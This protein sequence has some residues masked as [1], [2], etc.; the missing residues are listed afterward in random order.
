MVDVANKYYAGKGDMLLLQIDANLLS[1]ILKWEPPAHIDG[2]PALPNEPHYPHIYGPINIAAVTDVIKFPCL[3]DG[4]FATPP[5]LHTFTICNIADV[6]QHWLQAAQW[7]VTTWAYEFPNDTVQTYLDL[8]AHSSGTTT[9][10]AETFAAIN[11]RGELLGVVTLIDDDGLPDATEPGPWV[12]ALFVNPTLR[13]H[14]VGNALLQLATNRAM[15]LGYAQL[16]L[17]TLDQR[18]WYEQKGWRYL[19]NSMLNNL[20]HIVMCRDLSS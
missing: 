8:Y 9:R 10:L 19:R 2:S 11:V 7:G 4:T 18:E 14:G 17:Y 20:P 13:Q 15:Q 1:S 6:P 5:Q 16:F 3:S 12:A